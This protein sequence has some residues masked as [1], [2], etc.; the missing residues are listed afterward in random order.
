MPST[1][2]SLP[3]GCRLPP[4]SGP[5]PSD[6][7]AG[8]AGDVPVPGIAHV[9]HRDGR[10]HGLGGRLHRRVVALVFDGGLSAVLTE[11]HGDVATAVGIRIPSLYNHFASKADLYKAVL[12]NAIPTQAHDKTVVILSGGN[13]DLQQLKSLL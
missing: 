10:G 8:P 11:V 9:L 5:H 1:G 12:S 13:V 7:D 3:W 4:P 2:W 6:S